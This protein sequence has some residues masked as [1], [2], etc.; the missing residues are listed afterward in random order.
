MGA[1]VH[2]HSCVFEIDCQ[3]NVQVCGVGNFPD[4]V[5]VVMVVMVGFIV[6]LRSRRDSLGLLEDDVVASQ[7]HDGGDG[8]YVGKRTLS[9]VD[10]TTTEKCRSWGRDKH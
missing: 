7:V 6:F 9:K 3:G 8:T 5:V 10:D 1:V 4:V 2:H